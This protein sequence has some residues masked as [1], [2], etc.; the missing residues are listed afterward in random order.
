VA[1]QAFA[2]PFVFFE[3]M[4]RIESEFLGDTHGSGKG[5]LIIG[6]FALRIY[7]TYYIKNVIINI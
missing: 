5:G 7:L 3:E 6:T 2:F 4:G 1:V